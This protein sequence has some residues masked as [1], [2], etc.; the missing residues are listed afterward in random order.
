MSVAIVLI[1]LATI[2][3]I[4][5]VVGI[6]SYWREQTFLPE[7]DTSPEGIKKVDFSKHY[8]F[9]KE[10]KEGFILNSE[11]S[12]LLEEFNL[13]QQRIELFERHLKGGDLISF[14]SDIQNEK[15]ITKAIEQIAI[16]DSHKNTLNK[17]VELEKQGYSDDMISQKLKIEEGE[18]RLLKNLLSMSLK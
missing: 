1:V 10:Q 2:G 5:L 6:I 9:S 8:E 17:I 15:D 13:M 11:Y 12:N 3:I 16:S 4:F 7:I 18:V 14:D